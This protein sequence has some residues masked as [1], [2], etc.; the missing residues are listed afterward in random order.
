M[1]MSAEEFGGLIKTEFKTYGDFVEEDWH[2]GELN[3]LASQ[4]GALLKDR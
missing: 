3:G 4:R 2:H 1:P